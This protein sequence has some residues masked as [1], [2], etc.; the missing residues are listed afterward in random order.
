MKIVVVGGGPGGLYSAI[1]LKKHHP[2]LEIDVYERNGPDD[3][4]GWGVVFSDETLGGFEEADPES[5]AAIT[6]SFATWT[7]I[8]TWSRGASTAPSR[9]MGR[10]R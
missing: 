10:S 2:S 7:D 4:F 6:D 1:L 9:D 3:T 5:Y 8:E